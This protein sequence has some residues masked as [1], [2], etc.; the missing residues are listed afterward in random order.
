MEIFLN[1]GGGNA[2]GPNLTDDYLIH[3]GDIKQIF[4]TI[5]N[6]A[7]EK[8][9]PAWGKSMSPEDVK[10]VTFYV[11][12]LLGTNPADAKAPQGELYKP[13][14]AEAPVEADSTKAQASL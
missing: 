8:G 4:L 13:A 6:G 10:D 12:S 2:I 14:P 7:I 9:M 1:D 5:K 11:M 3:G